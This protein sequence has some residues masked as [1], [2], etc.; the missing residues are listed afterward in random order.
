MSE[1]PGL[2]GGGMK[3][4]PCVGGSVSV[5]WREQPEA[6]LVSSSEQ[7]QAWAVTRFPDNPET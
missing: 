1:L 3:K 5:A 2:G 7:G 4:E 6:P